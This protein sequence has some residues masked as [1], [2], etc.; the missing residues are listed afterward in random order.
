MTSADAAARPTLAAQLSFRHVGPTA[1][2]H[3]QLCHRGQPRRASPNA[4]CQ[5]CRHYFDIMASP[6]HFFP[7]R[8]NIYYRHRLAILLLN[9]HVGQC[10]FLGNTGSGIR[11][12]IIAPTRYSADISRSRRHYCRRC[13]RAAM[14]ARTRDGVPISPP[15]FA[16]GRRKITA[17]P[18][19]K[20]FHSSSF[21][22]GLRLLR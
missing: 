22:A 14:R 3:H 1:R 7:P 6:A 12:S 18:Y 20:C 15:A 13:S 11:R 2:A 8:M 10:A 21:S 19:S 17:A 4:L 9:R 16:E 5:P